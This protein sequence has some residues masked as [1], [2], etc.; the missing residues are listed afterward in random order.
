MSS[1]LENR[2]A[3]FNYELTRSYEAGIELLGFEVKALRA[4]QGNMEGAYALVRGGEAFLTGMHIP[5]YQPKNTP[6]EYEPRRTRK[7]LLTKK[8]IAELT[9]AEGTKG[10]TLIPISVYGKGRKIKVELALARGKK[11]YDKRETLKRRDA[12]RHMQRTLKYG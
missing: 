11:K 7:L 4:K 2:K 6:K 3:K 12:E 8:E 5:P 1:L 9:D 10:L